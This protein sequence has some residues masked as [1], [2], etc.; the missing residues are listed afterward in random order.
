[1]STTH[2]KLTTVVFFFCTLTSELAQNE[3][4]CSVFI[5]DCIVLQEIPVIFSST[6]IHTKQGRLISL[7]FGYISRVCVHVFTCC[8]MSSLCVSHM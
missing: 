3:A 2:H 8:C 7:C 4:C 6:H 1:M 5:L